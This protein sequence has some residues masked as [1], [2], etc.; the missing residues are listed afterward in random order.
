LTYEHGEKI[1]ADAYGTAIMGLGATATDW[2]WE[3]TD[4]DL[5]RLVN[6]PIG[7]RPPEP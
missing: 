4:D 6:A 3:V 7:D 1:I 5:V 2:K